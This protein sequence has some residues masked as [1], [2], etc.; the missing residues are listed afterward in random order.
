MGMTVKSFSSKSCSSDMKII[1]EKRRVAAQ[2][3]FK[4]DV[5]GQ[6]GEIP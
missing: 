1:S 5:K 3:T 6:K 2:K 4:F